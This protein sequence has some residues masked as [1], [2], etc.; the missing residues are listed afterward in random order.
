MRELQ[1]DRVPVSHV[2]RFLDRRSS[3]PVG[4]PRLLLTF[5]TP[6]LT[7]HVHLGFTKL[8]SRHFIPRPRRCFRC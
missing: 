7:S 6:H 3:S 1:V 5:D 8:D 4:S 2:Y